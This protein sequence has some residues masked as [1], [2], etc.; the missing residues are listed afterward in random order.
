MIIRIL[1][2][3]Y[4]LFL[5]ALVLRYIA[6]SISPPGKTKTQ[7]WGGHISGSEIIS[8]IILW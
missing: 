1:N 8:F 3:V 5:C 2:L 7:P 6:L 4:I